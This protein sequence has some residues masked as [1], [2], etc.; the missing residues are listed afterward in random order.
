MC[1]KVLTEG[2]ILP[3]GDTRR[4]PDT[5]SAV[6]VKA[7]GMPPNARQCTE[8]PQTRAS[9]PSCQPETPRS[10]RDTLVPASGPAETLTFGASPGTD[11][12]RWPP[13]SLCS[14]TAAPVSS[15]ALLPSLR[16]ISPCTSDECRQETPGETCAG[17]G[18]K[19]RAEWFIYLT[20]T[21]CFHETLPR[22]AHGPRSGDRGLQGS[23]S[24]KLSFASSAGDEEN[25]G[26]LTY[27]NYKNKI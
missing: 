26:A 18:F 15:D 9:G 10:R 24:G 3:P 16:P 17:S 25:E 23:C 11:A 20:R 7:V 19:A 21:C 12:T 1:T 6:T 4:G 8:R 5:F 27:F 22:V 13:A 2:V 14:A